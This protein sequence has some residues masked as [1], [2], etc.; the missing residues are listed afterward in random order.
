MRRRRLNLTA[1]AVT[2]PSGRKVGVGLVHV[3][4]DP[5]DRSVVIDTAAGMVRLSASVALTIA[6]A[7]I[8]DLGG[9]T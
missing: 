1:E 6:E 2:D 3:E 4:I 9:A 7:I 5:G 8:E